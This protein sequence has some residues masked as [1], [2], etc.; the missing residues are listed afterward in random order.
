MVVDQVLLNDR[1][2]LGVVDALEV[3]P[4]GRLALRVEELQPVARH[5]P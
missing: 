2:G 1:D 3:D 4:P 5:A